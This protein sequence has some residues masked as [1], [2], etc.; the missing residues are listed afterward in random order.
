MQEEDPEKYQKHFSA[1]VAAELEADDLEDM[2]KG[3]R[4]P[5]AAAA[6]C[7]ASLHLTGVPCCRCMPP[8]GK[9]QGAR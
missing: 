1:F 5:A 4:L 2:Y 8:S 3:V 6:A 7:L 9:T